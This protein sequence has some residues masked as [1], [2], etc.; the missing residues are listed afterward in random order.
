MPRRAGGSG[1]RSRGAK[2]QGL[3][4][5]PDVLVCSLEEDAGGYQ[6][7]SVTLDPATAHPQILVSADGR[8][9]RRRETPRE[10]LPGRAERFEALRCVLGHQGFVSGRHRWAVEVLPGPDWALGVAREFLPRK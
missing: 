3:L 7:A 2:L 1:A 5:F 10:P 9:A 6:R 8:S 4:L